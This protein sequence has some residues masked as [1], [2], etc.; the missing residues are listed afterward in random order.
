M[1]W[2]PCDFAF[3][4]TSFHPCPCAVNCAG[5]AGVVP[6]YDSTQ[7]PWLW[8]S[9]AWLTLLSAAVH[10]SLPSRGHEAFAELQPLALPMKLATGSFGLRADTL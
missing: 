7:L 2:R 10:Y 8:Q 4:S 1:R 6:V 5:P 9:T 3:S